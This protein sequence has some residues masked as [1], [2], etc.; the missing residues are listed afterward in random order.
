MVSRVAMIVFF[1]AFALTPFLPVMSTVAIV[2]A[3]VACV[4]LIANA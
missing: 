2:A 4:A 1:G 3:G